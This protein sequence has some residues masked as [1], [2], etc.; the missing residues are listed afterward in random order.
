MVGFQEWCH[1]PGIQGAIDC[2]HVHIQKPRTL[3][4]EDYYY[5]K[6][7][8]FSIV[9]QAVV[10][11][12]KRFIDL[13]VGMPGSTND[14]RTLRRSGLYGNV[15]QHRILND[16][17][18]ISHE[19]FSPYLLGDKGYP[20]LT[21]LMVPYKD[22]HPLSMLERLYNKR[23][24]QGRPVVECA[25]GVIKCTWRELLHQSNLSIDIML[26]V[27]ATCVILYNMLLNDKDVNIELLMQRIAQGIREDFD[28][29]ND[30]APPEHRRHGLPVRL[31]N[32]EGAEQMRLRMQRHLGAQPR[33]GEGLRRYR[34]TP[35]REAWRLGILHKH[36]VE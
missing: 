32:E 19:G 36:P 20:L 5:H 31:H 18:G 16:Q 33:G 6:S 24:R 28:D 13:F 29:D 25:F 11:S 21:W 7:G 8:S 26:D 23:M 1:M 3:Y 10:D 17:D 34:R 14:M 2:T 15:I 27:V 4:A 35:A 22:D 12:K 30:G 9:A